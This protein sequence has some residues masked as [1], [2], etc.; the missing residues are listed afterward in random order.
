MIIC[1]NEGNIHVIYLKLCEPKVQ[2]DLIDG[3]TITF[4]SL[5]IHKITHSETTLCRLRFQL[6]V[7]KQCCQYEIIPC[8]FR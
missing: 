3:E 1:A 8:G 2:I 5:S 4:P 6:P 7:L